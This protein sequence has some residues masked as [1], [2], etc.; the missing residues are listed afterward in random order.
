MRY[1]VKMAIA[2]DAKDAVSAM[3]VVDAAL[4]DAAE[5]ALFAEEKDPALAGQDRIIS[6]WP[7]HEPKVSASKESR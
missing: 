6:F 3:R 4:G 7:T 5:G 1:T 2:V